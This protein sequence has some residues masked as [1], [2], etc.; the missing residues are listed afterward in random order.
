MASLLKN[1]PSTS[2]RSENWPS[3]RSSV[4]EEFV[5]RTLN[6]RI[7]LIYFKVGWKILYSSLSMFSRCIY[8]GAFPDFLEYELG[9]IHISTNSYFLYI[10]ISIFS[11]YLHNPYMHIFS[12]ICT[13]GDICHCQYCRW[14][15]KFFSIFHCMFS[16]EVLSSLI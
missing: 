4:K 16:T 7:S 13:T 11:I 9:S 3:P 8:S 5:W 2:H 14:Q 12:Y 1:E 15:C 10:H 6:L